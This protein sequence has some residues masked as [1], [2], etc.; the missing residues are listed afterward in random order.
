MTLYSSSIVGKTLC[1]FQ[2]DRR[3]AKY[4]SSFTMFSFEHLFV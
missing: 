2:L 1:V 3:A 4:F